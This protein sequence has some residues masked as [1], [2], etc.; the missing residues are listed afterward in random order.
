MEHGTANEGTKKT[1]NVIGFL[2]YKHIN[3]PEDISSVIE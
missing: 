3:H 1:K 2:R